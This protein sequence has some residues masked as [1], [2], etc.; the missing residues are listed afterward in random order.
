MSCNINNIKACSELKENQI[1]FSRC[2]KPVDKPPRWKAYIVQKYIMGFLSHIVCGKV[3]G[4]TLRNLELFPCSKIGFFWKTQTTYS[5]YVQI[6]LSSDQVT[7]WYV[8]SKTSEPL[9]FT[10]HTRGGAVAQMGGEF[11]KK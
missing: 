10:G 11:A 5:F 1:L 8:P 9:V 4:T 2:A 6:Y 7:K 3:R